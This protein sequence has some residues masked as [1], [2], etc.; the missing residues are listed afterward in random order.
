MFPFDD[1]IMM[2]CI[3]KNM[4]NDWAIDTVDVEFCKWPP[5]CGDNNE[6]AFWS[7]YTPGIVWIKDNMASVALAFGDP[8]GDTIQNIYL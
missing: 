1:V 6:L 5:F 2:T 7:L 8:A 3:L 4:Y